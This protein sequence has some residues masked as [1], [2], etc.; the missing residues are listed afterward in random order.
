MPKEM[1]QLMGQ[2]NKDYLNGNHQRGI[3]ICK[4]IIQ[5]HPQCD[6]PYETLAKIYLE[7][8][9]KGGTKFVV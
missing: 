8:A 6:S 5:E 1:Q 7:V 3:E 4:R 2:A 9:D